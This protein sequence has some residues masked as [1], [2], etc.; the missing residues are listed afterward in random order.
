M[1]STLENPTHLYAAAGVYTVTLEVCNVAGCDS[2]TDTFEVLPLPAASFDYA[3]TDLTVVFT[4]TSSNADIYLWEFGD[5]MTSTL[6]SP[7]YTYAASGTY[8]VTL[9]AGNV[10][11]DD[12]ASEAI[13]V[14]EPA[15][16]FIYL[17]IINKDF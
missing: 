7:S 4:N 3:A 10:C 12:M 5:G 17:P 15:G 14:T 11:G 13:T 16:F 9:T 2:A 6:E 8:T 1:T